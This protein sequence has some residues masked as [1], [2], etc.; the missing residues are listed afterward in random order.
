[1]TMACGLTR[2]FWL[3]F[4]ARIGVGVGE[5]TLTPATNS[6]IGDYFPREKIPLAVAVF[7]LSGTS[8]SLNT[9]S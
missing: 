3:V 4:L 5:A 8:G 7:Q 1:M 2:S 6:L 9:A